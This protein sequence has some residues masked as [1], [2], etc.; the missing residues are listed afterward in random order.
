[1]DRSIAALARLP[2]EL[3]RR[4][5]L[6]VVGQGKAAP[7]QQLATRL[8]VAERIQFLGA[9]SDVP[10]YLLSADLLLHPS[11]TEAAGMV[12]LEALQAGLPVLASEV[13][14]YAFHIVRAGAGK[15]VKEPFAIAE[16]TQLLETMLTSAELSAWGE[17]GRRYAEDTDLYSLAERAADIIVRTPRTPA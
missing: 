8:G 17:N 13:C 5:R 1:V 2:D 15:L 12:L 6:C 9:R 3:R 10:R 16:F 14:G 4:C 11:V 7:L